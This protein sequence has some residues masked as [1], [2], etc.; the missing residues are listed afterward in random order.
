MIASHLP[1]A[2]VNTSQVSFTAA[3]GTTYQIAVD[4]F[5]GASGSVVLNI[6]VATTSIS[7]SQPVLG[8]DGFF[9]FNIQSAP[10]LVLRVDATT[11]LVSW[12]AIATVTNVTG[13]MDFADTN[14]PNFG[15]RFYR[16]VVPSANGQPLVLSNAVKLPGG[17]FR[18][19]LTSSAGQVARIEATTNFASWNTLATITNTTGTNLFTDSTATNSPGRFY[20][21]VS[22]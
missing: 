6:S 21:A 16:V 18:F 7:L 11:D 22:P 13:N 8:S 15:L 9:H 10:G 12:T 2:G 14:S 4:G 5:A 19:I 17:E 3:S 1:G 20:R